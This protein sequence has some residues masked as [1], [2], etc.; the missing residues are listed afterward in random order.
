[1]NPP[2]RNPKRRAFTTL[3]IALAAFLISGCVTLTDPEASQEYH[4]AVIAELHPG[5]VAAQTFVARRP[6]LNGIQLWLRPLESETSSPG[7]LYLELLR[8]PGDP[9]TVVRRRYSLAAAGGGFPVTVTWP[10]QDNP[11]NQQYVLR[12]WVEGGRLALYGRAEDAYPQGTFSR[13]EAPQ[14][15]DLAFRLKYDY[16]ERAL[17]ADLQGALPY[18]WLVLPLVLLLWVPGR[19]LVGAMR[20]GPTSWGETTALSVGLSVALLPLA[21]LWSSFIGARWNAVLLWGVYLTFLVM[22]VALYSHCIRQ[23]FRLS[24]HLD[25]L[26]L[27]ALF[28][29]T[30]GVRLVMVRDLVTPAWVDG[31]HHTLLTRLIVESGGLPTTYLPY[32][33]TRTAAYH[34]GFHALAAAFHGLS[35]LPLHETL[36]ILGQVLNALCSTFAVYLFASSLSGNRLAG[37]VAAFAASLLSPMPAYYTSWGR[38]T[39]LTGLLLLPTGL[40]LVYYG[41][42]ER[43]APRLGL[44]LL[45]GLACAGLFLTH[46][47]V[48]AFLALWFLAAGVAETIRSLN[49]LPLWVTLPKV[50]GYPLLV[51]VV[52]ALFSLPWWPSFSRTMLAPALNAAPLPQPLTSLTWGYLTPAFGR[53]LLLLAGLGLFWALLRLRWFGPTLALWVALLFMSANLGTVRLPLAGTINK[54]SVEI[55]LFLPITTLAGY[56]VADGF[57]SLKRR[58]PHPLRWPY[59]V[60]ALLGVAA[61]AWQGARATL[62][63]VN[64]Q[65][66]LSRSADLQALAWIEAHLP[67]QATIL[68]NPFLWGYGLYAGQDGG[69]WITP[70]TGRRTIP[71]PALYGLG[72]RERIR[73]ISTLCRAVLNEGKDPARLAALMDSAGLQYVYIGQRGGVLSPQA[74]RQS[75]LF[76][77]IYQ[78]GGVYL[79]RR[80][81]LPT[82]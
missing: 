38:Y 29:L 43:G 78:E 44:T 33:E 24:L 34:P 52:A 66:V 14:P 40:Y 64:P 4:G 67:Q 42:Q 11:P 72:E 6:R 68:I 5:E 60:A 46:Y 75:A 22:L 28:L 1:M 18:L 56:F 51:A 49:R 20:C 16:D 27:A 39:Q 35:G 15:A 80:S 79:F 65:T 7:H 70:L 81:D 19:L 57:L 41:R 37:L 9:Q 31:V 74:L 30:L 47:R 17:L 58:L 2:R 8:H 45:A 76:R 77:L 55:S 23:G 82:R 50:I 10:P 48:A 32:V 59:Q 71:P 13:N 36:L 12:L 63:L 73:P 25:D 26:A 61:L 54:T 53:Q 21:L 62:P 69:Y 3:F